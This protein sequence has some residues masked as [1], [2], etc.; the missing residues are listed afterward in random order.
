[1]KLV[2]KE[3]GSIQSGTAIDGDGLRSRRRL[4]TLNDVRAHDRLAASR[5]YR[6]IFCDGTDNPSEAVSALERRETSK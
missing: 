5:N 2:P 6:S 3:L 1:M 4:P